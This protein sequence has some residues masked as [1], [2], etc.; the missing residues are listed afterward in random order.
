MHPQTLIDDT[1]LEGSY[2]PTNYDQQYLGRITLAEALQKSR[3][4]PAVRLLSRIGA[5]TLASWLEENGLPLATLD[6]SPPNLT[7]ALGGISIRAT[8]LAGL[9]RKLANCTYRPELPAPLASQRACLQTSQI[10]QKVGDSQGAPAKIG[11]ASCRER[12]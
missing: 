5:D 9:Y 3:N 2:N 4:T 11:R 7:L 8:D 1:P 6:N 10:L 12:V